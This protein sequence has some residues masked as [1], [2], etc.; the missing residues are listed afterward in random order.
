MKKMDNT[1]L[2]LKL[3]LYTELVEDKKFTKRCEFVVNSARHLVH[4]AMDKMQ[5]GSSPYTSCALF[6]YS[7]VF[8]LNKCS[9]LVFWNECCLQVVSR[10]KCIA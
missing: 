1:R 8:F 2:E 3:N 9:E 10:L 4:F 6:L 5:S 7:W